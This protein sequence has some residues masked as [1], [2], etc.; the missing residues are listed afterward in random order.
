[1]DEPTSSRHYRRG[2]GRGG[3]H[4]GQGRPPGLRGRDI[5]LFYARRQ[6]ERRQQVDDPIRLHEK[7]FSCLTTLCV[8]VRRREQSPT[9]NVTRCRATK[10]ELFLILPYYVG[11]HCQVD[12]HIYK[13]VSHKQ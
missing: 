2:G 7:H 1:M 3:P 13:I 12:I 9:H 4:R 8:V 10:I 11:R 6:Q 5:G